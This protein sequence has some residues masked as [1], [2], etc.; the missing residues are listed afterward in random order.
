MGGGSRGLGGVAD[1]AGG[2]LCCCV[3]G[4]GGEG[5]R[6]VTVVGAGVGA[7]V[8][9]GVGF[10]VGAGVG[11]EV[12]ASQFVGD[13]FGVGIGVGPGLGANPGALLCASLSPD[14][15]DGVMLVD[16]VACANGEGLCLAGPKGEGEGVRVEENSA[17]LGAN[18]SGP[19][20]PSNA[21]AGSSLWG[22][23]GG[24]CRLG[25]CCGGF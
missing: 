12:S 16:A 2:V 5:V 13:G 7:G 1:V 6:V 24:A 4:V 9:A 22:G 3:W 15:V 25:V 10:G 19:C 8:V 23:G 11:P 17:V 20:G 14:A 18:G 21:S